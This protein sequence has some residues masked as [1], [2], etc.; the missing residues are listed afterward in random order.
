MRRV[1]KSS[2]VKN[3]IEGKGQKKSLKKRPGSFVHS[4]NAHSASN[5]PNKMEKEIKANLL[6]EPT[7][8]NK[9]SLGKEV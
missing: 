2:E 1:V 7:L 5:E 3:E 4:D 9:H 6:Q 8:K